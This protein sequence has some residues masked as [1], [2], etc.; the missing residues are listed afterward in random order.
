MALVFL[1]MDGTLLKGTS[2]EVELFTALFN[3]GLIGPK[4]IFSYL[5][6][7]MRYWP[8]FGEAVLKKNKAYLNGLSLPDVEPVGA[9]L[10]K[11]KLPGHFNQRMMEKIREHKDLG[12]KIIM[13]SGSPDFIIKHV[14]SAISAD[15]Y[16]AARLAVRKGRFISALPEQHPLG[17]EKVRL[18]EEYCRDH[19]YKMADAT[20][21]A[22]SIEDLPLLAKAGK[23]VAVTPD[24]KLENIARN[25]NWEIIN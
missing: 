15:D 12:D 8:R 1:D 16:I 23:A 11:H 6:F 14:A 5:L 17:I 7:A 4:Q 9:E 24:S 18:A 25:N 13:L 10:A 21:Y 22:D 20:A 2:C 3:K 19:E